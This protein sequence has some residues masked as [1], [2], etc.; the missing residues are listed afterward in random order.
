MVLADKLD[1]EAASEWDHRS[2]LGVVAGADEAARPLRRL[3]VLTRQRV[4]G[5]GPG[6]I[7]GAE[8]R[9]GQEA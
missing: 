3:E 8:Q 7:L 1:D 9:L 2:S 5:A 6:P 4:S